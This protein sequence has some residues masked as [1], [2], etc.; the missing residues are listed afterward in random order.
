[1]IDYNQEPLIWHKYKDQSI[2]DF[3]NFQTEK[4]LDI[5]T[6]ESFGDEW[7]KFSDFDKNEIE[8]MGN[9]YFDLLNQT[10]LNNDS[11]VLDLGC[12]TGRWSYYLSPKVKFI[13]AIDPSDAVFSATMLTTI[14]RNIR[15]TKAGLDNI[16]FADA[17]FDFVISLG[18]LH[19]IHDINSALNKIFEKTKPG[20]FF[21][22]YLYY[23]FDDREFVFKMVFQVSN[24]IRKIVS[25][26]PKKLKHFTA[27]V[28]AYIIYLPIVLFIRLCKYLFPRKAF[29]KKIPLYYYYNKSINIIRNDSLDRFGT[30]LE[31]RFSKSEIEKL[32]MGVGFQNVIFS[33]QRPFW[34]CITQKPFIS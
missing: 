27:E 20:G 3:V 26:M 1:M 13:E 15:V 23:D 30:P 25:K 21:L 22:L 9:E 4:N 6:V 10:P 24:F 32:L 14:K 7:T 8:I 33:D 18:V 34:H 29:Y 16:P 11:Y 17:S 5:K 31:K 12:G 2:A 28:I 19:H